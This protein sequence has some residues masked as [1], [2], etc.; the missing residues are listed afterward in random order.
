VDKQDT[1]RQETRGAERE[2]ER[3]DV[4]NAKGQRLSRFVVWLLFLLC[5]AGAKNFYL[6]GGCVRKTNI[7]TFS[8]LFVDIC[9]YRHD[10]D[11]NCTYVS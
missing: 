2:N 8:S 10:C 3:D 11:T 9:D 6:S 5:G 1:E 4:N 7:Y